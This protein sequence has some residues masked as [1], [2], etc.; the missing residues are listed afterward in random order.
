MF[1]AERP[2]LSTIVS[3]VVALIFLVVTIVKP[4][5]GTPVPTAT[6]TA[7]V[8]S[9]GSATL[10]EIRN[11][12]EVRAFEAAN[13]APAAS[14]QKIGMG[15]QIRTGENATARIE[16]DRGAVVRLAAPSAGWKNLGPP[17]W[18]R[19]GSGNGSGRSCG[20]RLVCYV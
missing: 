18:R 7:T 2:L 12:V 20:A 5:L 14:A 8:I 1:K 6:L 10:V 11:A 19:P 16:F 4:T 13:F 15:A 9:G 17:L 3:T